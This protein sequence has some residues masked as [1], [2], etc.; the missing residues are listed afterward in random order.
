MPTYQP[1]SGGTAVKTNG[2]TAQASSNQNGLLPYGCSDTSGSATAQSC[3]TTPSFTPTAGNCIAYN[4]TTANT[5]ALTLNVNSSAADA[6]QK[7]LGTA[8]AAGDMPAGYTVPLCFDGSHW[9]MMTIG[10]APSG[11]GSS[12]ALTNITG[13]GQITASGCTQSASTGG[14]C[15]ISGS[16]TAAVTFSV[17]PGTYN[18]ILIKWYGG[19]TSGSAINA[20]MTFNGDTGSN[21][22]ANGYYQGGGSAPASGGAASQSFC[23]AGTLSS[24]AAS[25]Q[26]IELPGYADTSFDKT[27]WSQIDSFSSVSS[28]SDNYQQVYDCLWANT[29]AITSITI[30]MPTSDFAAGTKFF[31][32][33]VQ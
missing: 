24:A 33:G 14:K 30:T 8:L 9:Q 16:S 29:A 28:T 7:W 11:G 6:V 23:A 2:G 32:Y 15:A 20:R 26:E 31:V 21:Y 4:T 13:S 27:G 25:S 22:A 3:T 5:G 12:G 19:S 17:L 1:R 18:E 10:N